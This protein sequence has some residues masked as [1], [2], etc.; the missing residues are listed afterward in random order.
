MRSVQWWARAGMV[1]ALV[2]ASS[3]TAAVAGAQAAA[4][5]RPLKVVQLGDSYSAGNGAGN[6]Y[7]PK[8][9]YRSSTNWAERYLD[10]L[11]DTYNV[12]FVNRACSGGVLSDLTHTRTMDDKTVSVWVPDTVDK[13]DAGARAMLDARGDCT[14]TYRDDEAYTVAPFAAVPELGGTTVYYTCKRSMEPQINAVGRDTDLVLFTIGGNDIHFSDIVKQCFALGFRDPGDCRDK[15]DA[16]QAGI[17]DVGVRTAEFLRQ[18]KARMRPD[19]HIILLAYPYLEKNPDYSLRGGFLFLDN[20]PVGREIRKLGD[21]GDAG[22]RA[23]VDAVNAEGGTPVRYIDTVKSHFAGH[24][25]DGRV[26]CRNPDRWIHE[27]DTFTQMEWYHYNP[28]G[29][30]EVANLIGTTPDIVLGTHGITDGGAVDIAFVI[31]TTGSMGSSIDSVKQAATQLV[32]DVR[33]RTDGARFALVDY[34]DFPEYTG[35][36]GDYPSKLDQDFTSDGA[37]IDAAIDGLQ[38]DGGGDWPESMYSGIARAFDLG[39]RPAVKKVVVVLA[40]A[41][42]HDPEPTTGLTADDI[43]ARSLAIDP[44]ETSF[45]DVGGADS[46]G[47]ATKIAQGTNGAVYNS[48]PSDAASAFSTALDASLDRPYAW[49]GGPYVAPTGTA[50]TF[51]G[52]GSYG[53]KSDLVKYEWDFDSD[54]TYDVVGDRPTT[55]Q[56]FGGDR[57]GL[58]TLRVT[59]ADGRTALGTSVIHI[60][61][62]GDE[63]DGTADNCPSVA[64]TDQADYD[65]DGVGDAC[66]DTP[67]YPTKDKDGVQEVDTTPAAGGGSGGAGG[68]GGASQGAPAG[69]TGAAALR[70]KADVRITAPKLVRRGR[71][72][73]LKVTCTRRTGLCRGKVAVRVAG[74]RLTLRYTVRARKTKALTFR[75]PAGAQRRLA[76][77]RRL[78][79]TVSAT[80]HEGVTATRS[81]TLRAA[82]RR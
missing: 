2:V 56:T 30:Q 73:Q 57:K 52:R 10:S 44:V 36:D 31:D 59:D 75:L 55:T 13:D 46:G 66:D 43:V 8:D 19:A 7:G 69:P 53:V 62:D 51:D 24:E 70:P 18:L 33:A 81:V 9:C 54:G 35:Y 74:K 80:T 32:A 48:S 29:H 65:G 50:V 23:A 82:R 64:N 20:Y 71:A 40:D 12:T 45:V 78:A 3:L 72:L 38:V 5:G 42:P 34:R 49:A 61:G 76:Q 21:M 1:C 39:W 79:V 15:I 28:T 14:P 25:P 26:C 58:V 63:V 11:R 4:T 37:A 27:F 47:L 77:H 60:S 67:G 6:Y 17:G 41:P 22:Q 68:A 16:G